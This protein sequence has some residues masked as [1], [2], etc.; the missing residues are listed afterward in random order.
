LTHDHTP[1]NASWFV[2]FLVVATAVGVTTT[3]RFEA[4]FARDMLTPVLF[5]ISAAGVFF[6]VPDTELP[7]ALLG[8]AL[9][10]AFL[11]WPLR[12]ATLGAAGGAMS[13]AVY[14]RAVE[15]GGIGRPA[16]VVGAMACLA[17]LV[18]EPLA[19]ALVPRRDRSW[20]EAAVPAALFVPAVAVVQGVLALFASRAAG[21]RRSVTVAATAAALTVIG[22]VVAG[23]LV[24]RG[25]R[26]REGVRR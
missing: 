14:V 20:L 6:A 1:A 4:S 13:I 15:I 26:R 21:T 3:T 16:S 23:L 18:G 8:V 24:T 19:R 12:R 9:P 2:P 7:G 22:A 5:A 25:A 10:I 17:L 11:A